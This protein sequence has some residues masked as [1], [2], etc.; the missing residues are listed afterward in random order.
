MN[1]IFFCNDANCNM[2]VMEYGMSCD[3][4]TIDECPGCGMETCLG[5]DG[6]CECCSWRLENDEPE[7]WYRSESEIREN[8][9]CHHSPLCEECEAYYGYDDEGPYD[10]RTYTCMECSCDFKNKYWRN[11]S[12][13]QGCEHKAPP[14]TPAVDLIGPLK[15]EI[16]KIREKLEHWSSGMTEGQIDNWHSLLFIR[17]FRLKHLQ[18]Q[19]CQDGA[20]NQ[21]AHMVQDGCLDEQERIP[22]EDYEK[23]DLHK[24]DLQLSRGY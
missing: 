22:W 20:L 11:Q 14:P 9:D 16:D 3:E 10:G 1:H 21:E 2:E 19:G 4:H 15:D 24:L 12:L 7:S 18:C 6:F 5:G 17:E 8:C 13:C 23:D